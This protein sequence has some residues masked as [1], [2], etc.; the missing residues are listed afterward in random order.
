MI[1][2]ALKPGKKKSESDCQ[3]NLHSEARML[4]LM[5]S[6]S[7]QEALLITNI[8]VPHEKGAELN[9]CSTLPSSVT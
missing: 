2:R 1:N 6:L 9:E 4:F 3:Q 8:H 5:L 7:T